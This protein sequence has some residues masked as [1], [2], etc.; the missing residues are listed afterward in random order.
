MLLED[1]EGLAANL[2]R[3]AGGDA[4]RAR[5]ACMA[6]LRR[7]PKVEGGSGQVYLSPEMARLFEQ[8]EQIAE[9]AGD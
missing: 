2:I 6:E 3:A 8:A 7:L 4:E 5:K 9:K 1:K